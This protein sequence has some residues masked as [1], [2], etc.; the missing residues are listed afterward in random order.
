MRDVT[1]GYGKISPEKDL[2]GNIVSYPGTGGEFDTIHNLYNT[3]IT[4][5]AELKPSQSPLIQ[6]LAELESTV[7]QPSSIKKMGNVT[8]NE[9]EKDFVIDTWTSLNKRLV[10]PLIKTKMF[11]NSPVGLQKLMLETLIKKNKAA[12]KRLTLNKFERIKESYIENKVYDAKRKVTNQP[13]QGF[14]PDANP[15]F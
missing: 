14:Q 15:L 9:E 7:E 1:P 10:E 6:K 12:S 8:L 5:S 4:P 13:A 3:A 11:Q 2:V